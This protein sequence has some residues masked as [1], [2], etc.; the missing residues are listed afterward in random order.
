M[1]NRKNK[2]GTE[3]L[4]EHTV[5]LIISAFCIVILI[6]LGVAIYSF[7]TKQTAEQQQA[8]ATL[9]LLKAQIEGLK[10]T[11]ETATF[12]AS[13]PLGWYLVSFSSAVPNGCLMGKGCLCICKSI[14]PNGLGVFEG[15]DDKKAAACTILQNT[16]ITSRPLQ[17]ALYTKFNLKKLVDTVEIKV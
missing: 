17:I 7:L 5:E 14:G 3:L 4:G 11:G 8:V 12:T 6:F 9:E 2:K 13:N 16:K 15:C 1:I 10:N